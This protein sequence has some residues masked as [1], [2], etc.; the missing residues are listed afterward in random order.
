MSKIIIIRYYKGISHLTLQ[1][2]KNR[3]L[4]VKGKTKVGCFF[5]HFLSDE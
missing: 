4:L 2:T 5:C 3:Y 1:S